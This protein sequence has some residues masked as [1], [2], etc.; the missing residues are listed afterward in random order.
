MIFK[1]LRNH[2]MD[3][4]YDILKDAHGSEILHHLNKKLYKELL[5]ADGDELRLTKLTDKHIEVKGADR[6][7]L[8]LIQITI[9]TVL[10]T[11]NVFSLFIFK[12]L[13][14]VLFNITA[15]TFF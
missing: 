9:I 10:T 11:K 1:L 8:K 4:G 2:G 3:E 12:I 13:N 15:V 14:D 6:I 5:A 7:V